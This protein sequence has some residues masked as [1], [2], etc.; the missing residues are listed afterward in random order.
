MRWNHPERGPI[1]P[2]LF[3]PIA[4]ET[5]PDRRAGRMGAAPGVRAMPRSG[6]ASCASRSMSRPHPVR[7]RRLPGDRHAAR[8]PRPGST[9]DRLELEITESVFLG[10]G[11][12]TDDDVQR[13]QEASACGWR[14][15]ISAP[16]IPRSATCARRRSTRSRSTRASSRG[17]TEPDETN[18]AAIITAIV[19]LAEALEHGDHR[20]GRRGDGRAGS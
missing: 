5:Q 4:E 3:I 9:P 10:D 14:S 1:S 19:S 18:N 2:A 17:A 16:A 15:T 11:R 8:S 6:R 20:R 12:R 7:R 13:A